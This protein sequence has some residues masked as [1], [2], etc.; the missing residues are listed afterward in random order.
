MCECEAVHVSVYPPAS[1]AHLLFLMWFLNHSGRLLMKL[2][3][4]LGCSSL[5]LLFTGYLRP[6][7]NLSPSLSCSGYVGKTT[8]MH[9]WSG[10][11]QGTARRRG[12]GVIIKGIRLAWRKR[13]TF[14]KT[15][16]AK[17]AGMRGGKG[18]SETSWRYVVK[19]MSDRVSVSE[20]AAWWGVWDSDWGK[21][22]RR[23]GVKEGGR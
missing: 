7:Y 19:Q 13:P 10:D 17:W 8:E 5:L 12:I 16:E 23:E 11:N 9:Q 6:F 20:R 14:E 2:F 15:K 4:C 22:H 1:T 18:E 3:G 21:K